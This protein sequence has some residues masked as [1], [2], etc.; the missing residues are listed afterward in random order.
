MPRE[1]RNATKVSYNLDND[2][3][4]RLKE[5]CK[6]TGRYETR[7]IEMA[8]E[9]F[10]KDHMDELD[11]PMTREEFGKYCLLYDLAPGDY[12]AECRIKGNG[13]IVYLIVGLNLRAKKNTIVIERKKDGK[14][15]RCPRSVLVLAREKGP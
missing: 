6:K 14:E 13:P 9:E 5:Y 12:H 4:A 10:L 3:L 8:I 1:K 7:A 11:V 2:L 15:F